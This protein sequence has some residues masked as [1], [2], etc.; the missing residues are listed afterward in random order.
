MFEFHGIVKTFKTDF[1][2]PSTTALDSLSFTV[3]P[4]S[5]TGLL[6]SNGAGK[7]TAIKVLL[8]LIFPDSGK[9]VFPAWQ[10]LSKVE[11]L[12]KIGYVPERPYFY[13]YLTALEFL[14][15]MGHLNGIERKIL[16]KRI[17]TYTEKLSIAEH[18]EKKIEGYSKG[19]LQRLALTA[20]LLH[21][22]DLLIFD[23]PTSGIDPLGRKEI[24]DFLIDL[25]SEGKTILISSHIVSDLEEICSDIIIV[26]SGK[27]AYQG[28]C[29]DL[30]K[31]HSEEMYH[32]TLD[33]RDNR[34]SSLS[35]SVK[36]IAGKYEYT[37]EGNHR[38]DFFNK[39]YHGGLIPLKFE[40]KTPSLEEIVYNLS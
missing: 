4:L 23:E 14:N 15:Y 1:W 9:V 21:N 6:G 34:L 25:H 13:P 29:H 30:I 36:E 11:K 37:F 5:L 32:A 39:C 12:K 22:P 40:R 8:E 3:P 28:R 35:V 24:K 26:E 27:L 33:I 20:S 18:L 10:N 17:E 31:K 7:T 38:E 2:I 19:M 16:K